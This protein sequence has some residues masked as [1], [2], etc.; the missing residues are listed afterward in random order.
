VSSNPFS[1]ELYYRNKSL[2]KSPIAYEAFFGLHE[3]PFSLTPDPR[4][5]VRTRN[6]HDTLRQV[7]R[8][9]LGRKGLIVLTGEVGTG[10]SMLLNSALQTLRENQG[11]GN[12]S[13]TAMVVHPTLSREEF[14]EAILTE[15]QIP[16]DANRRQGS[17]E[18]LRE[19]L[20]EVQRNRGIAVLGIDE[21]QLLSLDLLDE[22][23][24]LLEMRNASEELLQIV[25]CGHPDI[26]E[27]LANEPHFSLRPEAIV[28]CVTTPLSVDDTSEY[29][30]HRVRVAGAKNEGIFTPGACLA[31]SHHA[32]GIPRVINTLCAQA[33]AI[34]ASQGAAHVTS[35]MISEAAK[36]LPF[37]DGT[38]R[39]PQTRMRGSIGSGSTPTLPPSA[40]ARSLGTAATPSPSANASRPRPQTVQAQY[41]KLARRPEKYLPDHGRRLGLRPEAKFEVKLE[42]KPVVAVATA[43][44]TT[45]APATKMSAEKRLLRW[46]KNPEFG[47]WNQRIETWWSAK[48]GRQQYYLFVLLNVGL[49]GAVLLLLAQGPVPPEPWQH[50]VQSAI[51]FLGL[52]CLDIA[53]GLAGYVYLSERMGP[54]RESSPAKIVWEGYRR[55]SSYL[56]ST[57]S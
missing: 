13:R 44:K 52:I 18:A 41:P 48:L 25:L 30:A 33:L 16:Y 51:G 31:V 57:S 10:K 56:R 24:M 8:G 23:R 28:R 2:L 53:I 32:N 49:T 47:A 55:L 22:I 17:L 42:R 50:T 35:H 6:A 34:A 27:K 38:P 45:S 37:P 14:I 9:I 7:T 4:Y 46:L 19:M 40:S 5:L 43:P 15:F 54:A 21:A 29:I 36:K 1:A 39:G 26:E 12:K 20:L 3:N 11:T